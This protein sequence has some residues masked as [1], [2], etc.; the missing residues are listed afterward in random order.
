MPAEIGIEHARAV[1]SRVRQAS[2]LAERQF[3]AIARRQLL[4]LGCTRSCV[5]HWL[6]IGR[7][8]PRYPGVYAWGRPDLGI[9]GDLAC[10]LL[11]AGT[12]AALSGLSALWWLGL[13]GRRPDLIHL[14]A[15]GHSGSRDDLRIR[16]PA[17]IHRSLHRGL[18]VADLARCL[19]LATE[20]LSHDSLRLVLTR[21]EFKGL[22]SLHSLQGALASAPRGTRALRAAMDAHLPQLARCSNGF[23]RDFVLLCERFRLEIP[24]PNVRIGRYRPDMLWQA[25][26][27]I[28]ELDGEEAHHTPAQLQADARRQS[29]LESQGY[30]LLRFTW[31]ELQFSPS[32]TA[33]RVSAHLNRP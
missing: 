20:S 18:P 21:A 30:E 1:R 29:H 5:A 27:L 22:L 2:E 10:G 24:E 28:V 3:A 23:E 7:I 12:G 4:A 19:L 6:A 15:P 33:A 26:R 25:H 13:I 8:H 16:H 11:Y 32:S 14:D 31:P 17:E 9:Q